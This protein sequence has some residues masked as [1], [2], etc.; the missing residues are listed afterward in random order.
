M[1]FPPYHQIHYHDDVCPV[2]YANSPDLPISVRAS[3]YYKDSSILSCDTYL[4][5]YFYMISVV[6]FVCTISTYSWL[7]YSMISNVTN[8]FK[9]SR[10]IQSVLSLQTILNDE[11]KT[12]QVVLGVHFQFLHLNLSELDRIFFYSS[13][14][15]TNRIRIQIECSI[16]YESYSLDDYSHFGTHFRFY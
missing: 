2:A 15:R 14:Y 4:G 5:L 6:L 12:F 16:Y 8:D 1:S 7:I 10:H 9:E 3:G 11:I 13:L